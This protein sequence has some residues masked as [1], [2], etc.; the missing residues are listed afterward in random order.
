MI[1]VFEFPGPDH[2]DTRGDR[3]G[4]MAGVKRIVFRFIALRE[5]GHAAVFPEM[6]ETVFSAGQKL[7]GIGL[8][9]DV[10]DDLVFRKIKGPDKGDREFDGPQVAAQV[11]SGLT[12][13]FNEKP[14]DR[15]GRFFKP[16]LVQFSQFFDFRRHEPYF[17]LSTRYKMSFS[18]NGFDPG[19]E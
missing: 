9:T 13:L 17:F 5:A 4:G 7:I 18:I 16:L 8:M 3:R 14:A 6:I 2:A 12:D 19:R 11:S 1:A 10:E 15:S